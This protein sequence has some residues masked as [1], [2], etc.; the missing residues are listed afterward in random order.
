MMMDMHHVLWPE[1]ERHQW[2]FF[3]EDVSSNIASYYSGFHVFEQ[4]TM[5]E[6]DARVRAM[7]NTNYS[8]EREG[9]TLKMSIMQT[10]EGGWFLLRTHGEQIKEIENGEYKRGEQDV[11]LIHTLDSKVRI[12]LEKAEEVFLYEGPIQFPWDK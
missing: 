12:E 1:E 3:Y 8:V 4:T 11:F 10:T 9:D 7:L 2:Q 5:S 6:S